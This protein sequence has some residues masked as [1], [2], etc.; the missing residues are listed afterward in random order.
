MHETG[1]TILNIDASEKRETQKLLEQFGYANILEAYNTESALSRL[2]LNHVDLILCEADLAGTSGIDI[3]RAI[4]SND[5]FHDIPF[6]L[7]TATR[8]YDCIAE[9]GELGVAGYLLKP[10][11]PD[12]LRDKIDKTINASRSPSPVDFHIK[13]GMVYLDNHH[14]DMAMDEF[15]KALALNPKSPRAF[16]AMGRLQEQCGDH[17]SAVN[18]YQQATKLAPKFLR[19]HETLAQH[20]FSNGNLEAAAAELE[21]AVS[22]SP[23][24]LGRQI[25]LGKT[26][27]SIGSESKARKVFGN[28]VKLSR[29]QHADISQQVGEA[30]LEAGMISEAQDILLECINLQPGDVTLYNQLGIA[31]RKQKKFQEA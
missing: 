29:D 13:L 19:G 21:T 1:N 20:Y 23:K 16:L 17:D 8:D 9:A 26:L 31:Y 25:Q 2:M 22:I 30:Y 4:R 7:I 11:A 3:L 18:Y 15:K 5:D 12:V 27:I 28:V 14:H 6:L 10:F 24:N